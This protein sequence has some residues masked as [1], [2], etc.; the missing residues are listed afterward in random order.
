MVAAA[1]PAAAPGAASPAAAPGAA[2]LTGLLGLASGAAG[3]DGTGAPSG[4]AAAVLVVVV[5]GAGL[6]V[7]VS[8]ASLMV[9]GGRWAGARRSAAGFPR[10][11]AGSYC[12]QNG[13]AEVLT[14]S[15]GAGAGT[16][17]ASLAFKGTAPT[18]SGRRA[19]APR[20]WSAWDM[21]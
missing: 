20:C 14:Q 4:A 19:A 9:P 21:T 1:A 18:L 16:R 12:P 13:P 15:A 6:A 3:D 5:G 17:A 8:A 2:L 10:A 7:L 11:R